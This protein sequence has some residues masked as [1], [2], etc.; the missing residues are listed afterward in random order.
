MPGLAKIVGDAPLAPII[1]LG[2][3]CGMFACTLA[4]IKVGSRMAFT[5]A[6]DGMGV[7]AVSRA[8]RSRRTPRVAT[9]T[10]AGPVFFVPFTLSLLGRSPID[11]TGWSG[12]VATFGFM[13]A[14][15]LARS[16]R[17]SIC[18]AAAARDPRCGSWASS[19]P[20]S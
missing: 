6:R 19:Q 4:C 3:I 5:M 8:H 20:R 15:V 17:R 10:V 7:P 16:P 12:A 18:T 14:Y 1:D 2:L 11:L 9:W 13:L